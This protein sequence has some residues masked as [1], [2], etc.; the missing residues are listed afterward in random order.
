MHYFISYLQFYVMNPLEIIID[1][2]FRQC[3]QRLF[4]DLAFWRHHSW[5]M[6]SLEHNVLE[7]WRHIHGFWRKVDI[8]YWIAAVNI[9][10]L[11]PGIHGLEFKS[12]L[13]YILVYIYVCVCVWC[14]CWLLIWFHWFTI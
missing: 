14:V 10:F 3:R 11:P 5:S 2:S 13:F 7:M 4:C 12:M 6:T 9:D 8:D 1:R